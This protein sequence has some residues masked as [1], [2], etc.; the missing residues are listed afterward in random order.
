ML[1]VRKG[2][3]RL[4]RSTLLLA[5]ALLVVAWLAACAPPDAPPD[6]PAEETPVEEPPTEPEEVVVEM[7]LASFDP[8]EITV[9]VGTTVVWQD[10][11]G[12][13]HTVTS[14]SR[15]NPTELFDESV[16]AGDSFRFRFSDVGRYEYHCRLHPGMDAVVIVE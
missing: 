12:V 8:E 14:G 2:V 11:S 10:R 16:P 6:V 3:G 15:G 4:T 7:D 1:K 9:A 13:P 5:V